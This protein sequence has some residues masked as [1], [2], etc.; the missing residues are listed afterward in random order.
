MLY[1]FD[2]RR[3]IVI[4][5]DAV[6]AAFFSAQQFVKLAKHSIAQ[7]GIF[8]AALSGG[9]TPKALYELLS[10]EPFKSQVDW[11]K[12][13]LFWS[14]ERCV[15]PD[16]SES[17]YGTAMQAGLDSLPILKEN[18]FRMPADSPELEQAALNYETQIKAH[19]PN[20]TFDLVML[21]VG[22][23]GHTASLFPNTHG[24]HVD[25]P[26][27]AIANFLPAKEK[28]RMSLTFECIN[29]SRNIWI[30]AIGKGKAEILKRIF[31]SPYTP[32]LLPAQKVG[33]PKHKALWI[34]DYGASSA[35]LPRSTM[36]Y[37]TLLDT[38]G[39]TPLIKLQ[40]INS[41]P[42][43][44]ILVK[45]EFMNPGGSIKDR[46]VRHII[47][48]AER[49][50]LL[51]PGGTIIESTSGNTGAAAAMIAAIKGYKAILT[52]PDKVSKEK[53]TSMKAYGAEIIITPT[54]APA[55]SPEHYVNVAKKLAAEIPNSFRID[56]YDNLKNPEAHYLSTGPEIW[57]QSKGK[58]D[59]FVASASTGGTISGAGRFLKEKNP[60]L[61]VVMPDP[62]GSVYYAYHK[63]GVLPE[64]GHC[65]YLI[66][67][68]GED[69]LTKA[70][71]F[72]VI[73]DVIQV[74]D[75]DAFATA[76]LLA[77]K[78]G[79]LAGGSSGA[80]VWCALQ[81][82]KKV[83]R[84]TVIVTILPDGGVKYLSKM[85]DDQWMEEHHLGAQS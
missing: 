59:I 40:Q 49:K 61:K 65:T 51:K 16:H 27:L 62:I 30:T 83:E 3:D 19:V 41:N 4:A 42:L 71:D 75:K 15:S 21:G 70:I 29:A 6:D 1:S 56:Q 28:W 32:D 43:A 34:L 60:Q 31:T 74:T 18:I 24:L 20:G 85:F 9:S 13:L 78:E 69:H 52:M 84:P 37:P 68:I 64:E 2:D 7:R 82:A 77:R 12:V 58:I 44:T 46:I 63:T 5:G 55:N 81:L 26:R 80:N 73:D 50:Q 36:H 25:Q 39:S 57:E 33:T 53:Q 45:L 54:S 8:A 11:S 76:R 14:D 47:E 72:S 79:I 67:G 38:I 23:D 66:E 17:N 10:K 35:L 48:D 22:E